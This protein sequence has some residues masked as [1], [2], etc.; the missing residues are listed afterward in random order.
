MTDIIDVN[1]IRRLF[2]TER[3]SILKPKSYTD[4]NMATY[5]GSTLVSKP[6]IFEGGQRRLFHS[7]EFD[8]QKQTRVLVLATD[9]FYA[10]FF[11][12]DEGRRPLVL[13]EIHEPLV[14]HRRSSCSHENNYS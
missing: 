12:P 11:A 14:E 13:L 3:G 2:F 8:P 6:V 9:T 7:V 5:T 1:D 4:S 10:T